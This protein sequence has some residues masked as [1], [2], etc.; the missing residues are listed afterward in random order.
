[1]EAQPIVLRAFRPVAR[2]SYK[3]PALL[4]IVRVKGP[5]IVEEASSIHGNGRL[6]VP[7]AREYGAPG[8]VAARAVHCH[9]PHGYCTCILQLSA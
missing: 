6:L 3:A 2:L 9:D 8:P 7:V 4:Y 1:L 5:R